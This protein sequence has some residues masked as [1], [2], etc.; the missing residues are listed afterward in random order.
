ME[1]PVERQNNLLLNLYQ[2]KQ[3]RKVRHVNAKNATWRTLRRLCVLCDTI[4]FYF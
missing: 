3:D 1:K 2:G 4:N